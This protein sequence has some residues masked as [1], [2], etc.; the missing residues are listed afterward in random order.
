MPTLTHKRRNELITAADAHT[1][2]CRLETQAAVETSGMMI[3][4]HNMTRQSQKLRERFFVEQAIKSLG[5]DWV[6]LPEERENPDF[7]LADGDR[8]FGLEVVS[9]FAGKQDAL[10]SSMKKNEVGRSAVDRGDAPSI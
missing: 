6:V 10:G 1:G 5:K 7:I 9:V 8:R 2:V 3:L 4:E